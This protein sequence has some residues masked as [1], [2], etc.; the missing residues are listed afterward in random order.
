MIF[1]INMIRIRVLLTAVSTQG[2]ER[3][4]VLPSD[5]DNVRQL[6]DGCG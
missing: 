1:L 5:C 4:R 3:K 2:P 6:A